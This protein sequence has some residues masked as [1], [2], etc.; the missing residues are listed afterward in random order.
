[1]ISMPVIC[2]EKA[3]FSITG[4]STDTFNYAMEIESNVNCMH[5]NKPIRPVLDVRYS[6]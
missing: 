2:M 1:M 3:W 6:H 4:L 5:D